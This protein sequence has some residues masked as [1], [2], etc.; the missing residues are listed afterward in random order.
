MKQFELF[1]NDD[2]FFLEECESFILELEKEIEI[3][4]KQ[5]KFYKDNHAFE[6]DIEFPQCCD[7]HGIWLGFDAIMGNPPYIGLR[8][9]QINNSL[10]VYLK[11]NY[12]LAVGQFDTFVLFIELSKRLLKNIGYQSFI[13]SKRLISNENFENIRRFLVEKFNLYKYA[14]S[15]SP[16]ESVNVESNII[17]NSMHKKTDTIEIQI[18]KE[19]EL[20]ERGKIEKS[21]IEQF[22]FYIFPFTINYNAVNILN[23][24]KLNC[25]ELGKIV[26]IQRGFEFGFNHKSINKSNQGYKIIKGENIEKY[27]INFTN[28]YINADFN[29]K[30]T[31]KSKDIFFKTPKLVTKFVS[32][33]LV[34]S[35][36]DI[37]YCNTNVVYNIHLIDKKFKLL[38]LLGLLN[39]KLINFWFFNIYSNN[40]K[41]FPHIQKNQ[42]ESI[43]IINISQ[44]KQLQI[45]NLVDK[46]LKIKKETPQADT[47][48]IENQINTLVYKLYDLTSEEIKIIENETN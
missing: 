29:D 31:Y 16:F 45:S 35:Y 32:N 24:I 3:L 9:S 22:P 27:K 48:S 4:E 15:L 37:G 1:Q 25:T 38:F 43:P 30:K 33:T 19:N 12:E 18:L 44:N 10:K 7:Y 11:E 5:E 47:E 13:V 21:I 23:N 14:D 36:D 20:I 28:F 2:D 42:L 40:D 17:F 6:W 41:I 8:T 39:S 26:S 34:F 46:I